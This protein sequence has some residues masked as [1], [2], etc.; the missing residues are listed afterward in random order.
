V[1]CSG[2]CAR[3]VSVSP[4]FSR[5]IDLDSCLVDR[6]KEGWSTKSAYFWQGE[7]ADPLNPFG[8]Q[9]G[10]HNFWKL[11]QPGCWVYLSTPIGFERVEFNANRVF[12]TK[13]IL[14]VANAASLR[15]DE[16][17]VLS[18]S[19]EKLNALAREN[20]LFEIFHFLKESGN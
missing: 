9:S 15:L 2:I 17:T 13:T 3:Y 16:L 10:I 4:W 14:S 7:G 11:L 5:Q 8:Y 12:D 1:R 18:Q 6:Y 19:A 20:Y